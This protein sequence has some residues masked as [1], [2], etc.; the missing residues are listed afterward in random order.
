MTEY[1]TNLEQIDQKN[2]QQKVAHVVDAHLH[3]DT[4]LC[5]PSRPTEY[6]SIIDEN[7]QLV[8]LLFETIE[9]WLGE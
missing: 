7:M 2:G 9:K 5:K 8:L 6:A 3:L 1:F 4:I